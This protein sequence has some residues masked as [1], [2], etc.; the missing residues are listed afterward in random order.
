[1]WKGLKT[2][3]VKV[4]F[5]VQLGLV[6]FLLS[7]NKCQLLAAAPRGGGGATVEASVTLHQLEVGSLFRNEYP[8]IQSTLTFL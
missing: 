2:N 5:P 8:L 4:V 6:P 3:F 7:S 1:M